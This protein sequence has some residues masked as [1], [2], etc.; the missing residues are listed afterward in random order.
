MSKTWY[1]IIDEKKCI[2]CLSCVTF[3]PHGVYEA[4]DGKPL[5]VHPENCIELCH[6]CQ[7]HACS[8]GA[9][10]YFG[11]THAFSD[12]LCRPAP[13]GPTCCGGSDCH[14]GS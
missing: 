7:L 11:D 8:S 2:G 14:C 1:P 10:S 5:I 12:D 4:Y 3:C 6:G 13:G 9:I